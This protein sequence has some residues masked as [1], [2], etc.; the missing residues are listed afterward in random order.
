MSKNKDPRGKKNA[1]TA[2][3]TCTECTPYHK[4]LKSAF[5]AHLDQV[6]RDMKLR[7]RR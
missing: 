4:V 3:V 7:L 1:G 2:L 5:P 6:R